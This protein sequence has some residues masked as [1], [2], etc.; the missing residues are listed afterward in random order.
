MGGEGEKR[1]EDPSLLGRHAV[2][3]DRWE[4]RGERERGSSAL[5]PTYHHSLPKVTQDGHHEGPSL[6]PPWEGEGEREREERAPSLPSRHADQDDCASARSARGPRET[7]QK[8]QI[9]PNGPTWEVS[10][11]PMWA[12]HYKAEPAAQSSQPRNEEMRALTSPRARAR[13][14]IGRGHGHQ[15]QPYP[16]RPS[17]SSISQ[18]GRSAAPCGLRMRPRRGAP[19]ILLLHDTLKDTKGGH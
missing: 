5:S 14:A 11:H 3:A 16:L 15:A 8:R 10:N 9:N 6:Q 12:L 1:G 17:S 7:G 4:E 2:Q 18:G 19:R 13:P